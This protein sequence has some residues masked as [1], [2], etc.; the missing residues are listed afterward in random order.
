MIKIDLLASDLLD[1]RTLGE[2][3]YL[4]VVEVEKL[5]ETLI[6][7]LYDVDY[8][9]HNDDNRDCAQQL[10]DYYINVGHNVQHYNEE[11]KQDNHSP[12]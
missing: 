7:F 3:S 1:D 8:D 2:L 10:H 6:F 11:N 9:A 5:Y 12:S 4:A